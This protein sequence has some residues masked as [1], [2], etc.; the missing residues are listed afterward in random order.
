MIP[1]PATLVSA[2]IRL[3]KIVHIS[4]SYVP[5]PLNLMLYH[6]RQ[7][8]QHIT[9]FHGQTSRSQQLQHITESAILV[10]Y[11]TIRQ[12][13]GTR[14]LTSAIFVAHSQ[15]VKFMLNLTLSPSIR[16]GN[17]DRAC[18]HSIQLCLVHTWSSWFHLGRRGTCPLLIYSCPLDWSCYSIVHKI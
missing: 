13:P 12:A 5:H 3:S 2:M 11:V 6:Q 16:Q 18:T 10:S 7:Q 15:C 8:L 17:V 4:W 1:K 14:L 9:S